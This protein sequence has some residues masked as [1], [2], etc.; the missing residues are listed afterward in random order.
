MKISIEHYDDTIT[1]ETKNDDLT[2]SEVVSHMYGL[3]IAAGFDADNVADA[4][5]DKSIE[6]APLR[7]A[8]DQMPFF[9]SGIEPYDG[10][11]RD[12]TSFEVELDKDYRFGSEY[13]NKNI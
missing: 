3:C 9:E 1:V 8:S 4:F 5:M 7:N 13:K 12:D 6:C 11:L 10:L 2:I